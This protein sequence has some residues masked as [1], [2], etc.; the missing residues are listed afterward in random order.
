ME[1]RRTAILATNNRQVA[2]SV[3]QAVRDLCDPAAHMNSFVMS[4]AHVDNQA[5]ESAGE[6]AG[7]GADMYVRDDA[8]K[9]MRDVCMNDDLA[10]RFGLLCVDADANA[11]AHMI[12]VCAITKLYL[13]VAPSCDTLVDLVVPANDVGLISGCMVARRMGL[14]VRNICIACADNEQRDGDATGSSVA[15]AQEDVHDEEDDADHGKADSAGKGN[16]KILDKS[17]WIE[18]LVKEGRVLARGQK[19]HFD[20]G[21]ERMVYMLSG[22]DPGIVCMWARSEQVCCL[23]AYSKCR[24]HTATTHTHTYT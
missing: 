8:Q 15:N 16:P 12:T 11:A 7:I 1:G 17:A 18:A 5:A 14:P 22:G 20:A 10:R 2:S 13:S 6:A 19:M 21:M 4:N 9:L 24:V 23:C 3:S